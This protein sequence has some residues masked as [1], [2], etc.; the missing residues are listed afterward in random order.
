MP[1]LTRSTAAKPRPTRAVARVLA[2]PQPEAQSE[3]VAIKHRKAC[4]NPG[5]CEKFGRCVAGE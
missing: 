2:A 4:D 1:S 5:R 3:P